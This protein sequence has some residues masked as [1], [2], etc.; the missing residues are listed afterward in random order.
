[1]SLTIRPFTPTQTEYKTILKLRNQIDPENPSTVEI[2]QH[3]DASRPSDSK[4]E[5]WVAEDENGRLIAYTQFDETQPDSH[6]FQFNFQLQ[7][8]SW[9]SHLAE[10]LYQTVLSQTAKYAAQRL[11]IHVQESESEKL[12][13]LAAH[14]FARVMRSPL[15]YLEV[16]SFDTERFTAVFAKLASHNIH[17]TQPPPNWQHDPHWQHLIHDL[18]WTLMQDVPHHEARK[19]TPFTQFIQEEFNHPN[20]FPDGYFI[21]FHHEQP[22]GMTNFVKRGG[23][24]ERL[25]TSITGVIPAYRR[26]GI[27]TALKVQSIRFA[28]NIG[29]NVIITSNEENNPMYLLNIQLGFDPQPAWT[30]WEKV[31]SPRNQA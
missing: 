18:D 24:T 10:Q 17:I 5:R 12:A 4:F 16:T 2:W 20:F 22:V 21:A 15:S 9:S 1:M 26:Q 13:L 11:T 30:D 29:T 7:P 8:D 25:A 23:Q 28:Q 19:Q 31:L 6:K 27:A 14:G 3:W